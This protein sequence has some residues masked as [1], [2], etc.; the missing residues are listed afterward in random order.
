MSRESFIAVQPTPAQQTTTAIKQAVFFIDQI[1]GDWDGGIGGKR[2]A[3]D[4]TLGR[5]SK[6]RDRRNPVQTGLNW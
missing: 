4:V 1:P 6:Y 3:A 5:D 2:F